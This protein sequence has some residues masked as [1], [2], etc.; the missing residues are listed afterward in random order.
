VYN[1]VNATFEAS[2]P[3]VT[4]ITGGKF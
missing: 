1:A 3:T 4:L 2:S